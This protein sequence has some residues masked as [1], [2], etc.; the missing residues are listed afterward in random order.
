[1]ESNK[2]IDYLYDNRDKL[3]D[4]LSLLAERVGKDEGEYQIQSPADVYLLL[5]EMGALEQEE[6]RVLILDTRNCVLDIHTAYKGS[7]DTILVR[8]AELFREAI[9]QNAAAII[10]AHNHPS[11]NPSPSP[12]D[13][14]LTKKLVEAGNLLDVEVLDHLVIGRGRFVSLKQKGLGF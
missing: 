8:V 1:M 13:V 7:L 3:G 9:R 10:V 5:H 6:V 12:D 11:G 4:F 2:V 14:I